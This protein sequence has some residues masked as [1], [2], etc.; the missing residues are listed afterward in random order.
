MAKM[1]NEQRHD[2]FAGRQDRRVGKAGCSQGSELSLWSCQL[3][4]IFS[5]VQLTTEFP[6]NIFANNVFPLYNPLRSSL[7]DSHK[8]Q[9]PDSVPLLLRCYTENNKPISQNGPSLD[10]STKRKQTEKHKQSAKLWAE[11]ILSL[12]FKKHRNSSGDSNQ[13]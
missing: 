13:R 10:A 4:F 1:T 5:Q 3:D 11:Q 12:A 9:K 7:L 2:A 6:R 8:L